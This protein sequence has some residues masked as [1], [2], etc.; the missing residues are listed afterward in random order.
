[1]QLQKESAITEILLLASTKRTGAPQPASKRR[2]M[3]KCRQQSRTLAWWRLLGAAAAIL[4]LWLGEKRDF[5]ESHPMAAPA[6]CGGRR[7]HRRKI[8]GWSPAEGATVRRLPT[9]RTQLVFERYPKIGLVGFGLGRRAR[10]EARM[11]HDTYQRPLTNTLRHWSQVPRCPT[12]S[13]TGT[14]ATAV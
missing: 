12:Q 9:Q 10:S 1:V 3:Q 5:Q 7:A 11:S 2:W 14:A 4:A 6:P 8:W 13:S